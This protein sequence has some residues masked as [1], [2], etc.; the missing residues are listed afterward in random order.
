MLIVKKILSVRSTRKLANSLGKLQ[1]LLYRM[2]CFIHI[3][4]V[5]LEL[6]YNIY[7]LVRD[8]KMKLKVQYCSTVSVKFSINTNTHASFIELL[9]VPVG[10]TCINFMAKST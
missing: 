8:V 5:V 10:F 2:F 7:F 3:I 1:L 6:D 4:L 9:D